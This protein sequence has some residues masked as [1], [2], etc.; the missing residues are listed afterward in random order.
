MAWL[1]SFTNTPSLPDGWV[2]CNGQV[3]SDALSHYNGQT[4]PDINGFTGTPRFLRAGGSSDGSTP[5]ASGDTGGSETHT[6]T[7]PTSTR[8]SSP[9]NQPGTNTTTDATSS[10]PSYYEVVWIMRIR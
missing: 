10:L 3:L 9:F 4:I 2:E 1:K 5:T 6:H 8:S 7:I